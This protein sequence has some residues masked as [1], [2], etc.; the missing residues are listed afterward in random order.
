MAGI[1]PALESNDAYGAEGIG[2]GN[3]VAW[4]SSLASCTPDRS[5]PVEQTDFNLPFSDPAGVA[6][7]SDTAFVG[8]GLTA[9]RLASVDV[10]DPDNPSTI[11]NTSIAGTSG[12]TYIATDAQG[13][14][15]LYVTGDNQIVSVDISDTSNMT[16]ADTAGDFNLDSAEQLVTVGNLLFVAAS[17]E[18]NFGVIDISDPNN[19]SVDSENGFGVNDHSGVA[20]DGSSRAYI[21][22]RTSDDFATIDVSD[23]ANPSKDTEISPANFTRPE[24]MVRSGNFVYVACFDSNSLNIIDV[25]TPATPSQSGVVVDNTNLDSAKDLVK[26]DSHVYVTAEVGDRVTVVDVS[27]TANPSVV[28][29]VNPGDLP[30][31]IANQA[32]QNIKWCTTVNEGNLNGIC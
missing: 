24:R 12:I 21:C 7:V 16:Q 11:Q 31:S 1:T 6:I 30:R 25:S 23:P 4:V 13:R 15:F 18:D 5:A 19:M 2:T 20:E 3:E 8:R 32:S 28:G 9:N 10:S 22:G 27:D 17:A 26:V 14:D 29:N